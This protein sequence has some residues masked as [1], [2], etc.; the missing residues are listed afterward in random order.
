[1]DVV[2]PAFVPFCIKEYINFRFQVSI[3]KLEFVRAKSKTD[4]AA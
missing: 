3:W 4:L 1:M 2:I